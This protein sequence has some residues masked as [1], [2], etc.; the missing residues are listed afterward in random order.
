MRIAIVCDWYAPRRGGIEAHLTGLAQ[1]LGAGGHE[2]HVVTTTP[3]P[4]HGPDGATIHR[5][6]VPRLPGAGV[7]FLPSSVRA[8]GSVLERQRIDLVHAHVSIVA[9]VGIGGAAQA[10]AL[11]LPTV[12]TFH[13]FVPATPFWAGMA[14]RLVGAA[15]WN[16]VFSAV[17]TRVAREI[18]SFAPAEKV[19]IL[20]NAIDM[21][22]WSPSR[23]PSTGVITFVYAGRLQAKKRPLL[24]LR[25]MRDLRRR[26]PAI[27]FRVFIA[28]AGPLESSMRRF[29]LRAGLDEVEFVGWKDSAGLREIFR[30]ADVFLSP[31]LRES[32]GLAALEARSTGLPVIA[33]RDSAVADFITDGES[34]LLAGNDGDFSKAVERI[35][36]DHAL[37]ATMRAH[38]AAVKPP[39]D[40]THSLALHERLYRDAIRRAG[41]AA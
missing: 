30:A 4:R 32:F 22:F 33:M 21:A 24:V 35:A 13:S 19:E 1:R 11:G 10:Q 7:A 18:A 5:L 38:N 36:T 41:V 27:A 23:G 9:P 29:A 20:P 25:A 16:A 31:S 39:F 12:V 34:G 14:G 3:G 37:R 26:W 2:V 40:W 8:I 15:R 17:S 28:G 6:D